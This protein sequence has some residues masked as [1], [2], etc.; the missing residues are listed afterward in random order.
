MTMLPADLLAQARLTLDILKSRELRFAAAES[1]T[2]GLVLAALTSLAGSSA[3]VQCGFVTYSNQAKAA[4]LGIAPD[5]IESEGAVSEVVAKA[6]AVGAIGRSD[7]DIAVAITGIAG[8]DG[9]TLTKPV[10]LVHF[11]A[12]RRG[13]DIIHR[14]EIL[15]GDSDSIRCQAAIIALGLAITAIGA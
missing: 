15:S 8:P 12:L 6:M 9:G 3:V 2:G 7:A 11:A 5:L 10:G 13:G 14:C 4:M 1:C